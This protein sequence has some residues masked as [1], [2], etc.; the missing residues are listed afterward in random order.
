MTPLNI[1]LITSAITIPCLIFFIIC[2]CFWKKKDFLRQQNNTKNNRKSN[3][4]SNKSSQKHNSNRKNKNSLT[5]ADI[6][7]P[8]TETLKATRE[9][10]DNDHVE[11]Q[12]SHPDHHQHQPHAQHE[13]QANPSSLNSS[14]DRGPI[15]NNQRQDINLCNSNDERLPLISGNSGFQTSGNTDLTPQG[16]NDLNIINVPQ[17]QQSSP[18]ILDNHP[19]SHGDLQIDGTENPM[20]QHSQH[21]QHLQNPS[22]KLTHPSLIQSMSLNSGNEPVDL[23]LQSNTYNLYTEKTVQLLNDSKIR[24]E[25]ADKLLAEVDQILSDRES[26]SIA[27]GTSATSNP[28]SINGLI[29][30]TANGESKYQLSTQKYRL[31]TQHG[32]TA[33]NI[34]ENQLIENDVK[35]S[36]LQANSRPSQT[37]KLKP[38]SNSHNLNPMLHAQSLN[39]FNLKQREISNHQNSNSNSNQNS[40]PINFISNFNRTHSNQSSLKTNTISTSK[41]PPSYEEALLAKRKRQLQNNLNLNNNSIFST[42]TVPEREILSEENFQPGTSGNYVSSTLPNPRHK[43]KNTNH[44]LSPI[45]LSKQIHVNQKS[46]DYL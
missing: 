28:P 6:G 29:H 24:K 30:N 1:F 23:P 43:K 2:F 12:K 35:E 31:H 39:L 44:I 42:P 7:L 34:L 14:N 16:L 20:H 38:V 4:Q 46:M 3:S 10:N 26:S 33:S 13:N 40:N 15:L 32:T 22:H 9:L 36:L 5:K 25:R 8:N 18:I 27:L 19:D 45:N 17:H 41:A 21:Q 11:I 37:N